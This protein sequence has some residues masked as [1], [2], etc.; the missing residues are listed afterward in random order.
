MP[1]IT[2][3]GFNLGTFAIAGTEPRLIAESDI[4]S[5]EDLAAMTLHQIELRRAARRMAR[6]D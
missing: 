5:L 2:A 3:A 4:A 1:L 6:F